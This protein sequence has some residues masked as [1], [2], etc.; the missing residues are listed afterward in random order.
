MFC[1]KCGVQNPD[2]TTVCNSCGASLAAYSTPAQTYAGVKTCGFAIAALICGIVSPLTC[3]ITGLL[4][5]IFGITALMQINKSAG[6][7]KGNGL[8][9]TGIILPFILMPLIGMI[10]L[11]PALAQVRGM[12]QRT[13]CASNI[14]SLGQAL[15][16][17]SNDNQGKY[18]TCDKWCDLLIDN[19]GVSNR[20]FIC[21]SA[22]AGPC[23]YALNKNIE[24]QGPNSPSDMV[25]LF[26]TSPGWNQCGGEDILSTNN[27]K[28]AGC[29]ILYNDGHVEFVLKEGLDR[30]KWKPNE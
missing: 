29:N 4:A 3:G 17:Y 6:A 12:A 25:L 8:A 23:N 28:G 18:P 9:I 20:Q 22:S 14:S 7:L 13:I 30:L 24:I 16:I 10:I 19:A 15:K 11:M 21:K 5:V 26:E 27:H 1:P 2:G